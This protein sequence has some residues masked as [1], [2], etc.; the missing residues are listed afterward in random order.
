M[1]T[2][3]PR[4]YKVKDVD[5]LIT[6]ATI[7]ESAIANK[8]FLQ[9]KRSTWADPFFDDL[10]IQIDKAIQIHLGVDSAKKLRESTQV[11]YNI[12]NN[13]IKDLAEVKIQIVE[14]FKDTPAR[15]SE[16]LNQLGFTAYH[17][18]AQKRDQ[19]ALINLLY[20]YKTNLTPELKTE[21]VDKGTAALALDN[22]TAYADT[23]KTAN[24]IQEG[25]KG[26]RKV[27]TSEAVMEFN[28]IYNKVITIT[29]ISSKFLKDKPALKDQF[30]F[31][32]VA[33]TLNATKKTK[34]TPPTPQ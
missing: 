27:I 29:R 14:D 2:T 4:D 26:E 12:Q 10:K 21:I 28:K 3:L 20:Q 25:N 34:P 1:T 31:A 17:K 15:Q 6:A 11:V 16:I 13:A 24:V 32:K 19:E 33:K 23:L 5:M 7:T 8:T 9:S 22:I 30:S 18:D